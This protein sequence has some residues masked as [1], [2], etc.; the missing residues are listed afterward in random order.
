MAS[1]IQFRSDTAANW[2]SNNPILA[3]AEPGLEY[4]TGMFKFGDGSTHWNSLAYAGNTGATQSQA[5][6]NFGD[7]S[8]GNVSVSTPISLTKDMYYNNLTLTTGG[9]ISTN[10]WRI[11]VKGVLDLRTAVSGAIQNSGGA[12]AAGV[13]LF[14]GAAGTPTVQ[15]T[16]GNGGSAGS[17]GTGSAGVGGTGTAS[18]NV[19]TNGGTCGASGA[20]GAG[21]GGAGAVGIAARP[22]AQVFPIRRW[23]TNLLIGNTFIIGGNGGNG[24]G[25]GGGDGTN[26]GG[27]GGGGGSAAGVI[28]LWASTILKGSSTGTFVIQAKGGNGG[29]GANGTGG[30]AGGG[31]AGSGGGGGW[32]YIATNGIYGPSAYSAIGVAGGTGGNGGNGVGTGIGGAGAGAG[33]AGLVTVYNALTGVGYNYIGPSSAAQSPEALGNAAILNAGGQGGISIRFSVPL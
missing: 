16:L 29:N 31:G 9:Q 23:A 18:S 30:N 33:T 20:G 25:A 27:G 4:N 5:Y 15:N 13:G 22:L 7:G 17:G 19:A 8:D 24:G 32:V 28:G 2:T 21:S 10:G 12:G 3:I 11:F 26:Q 6:R 14:G 1:E